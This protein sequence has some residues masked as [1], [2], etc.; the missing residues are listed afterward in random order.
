MLI[1]LILTFL[2]CCALAIIH[3]F[4]RYQKRELQIVIYLITV[5]ISLL[6]YLFYVDIS[7]FFAIISHVLYGA[8]SSLF[9]LFAVYGKR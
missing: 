4:L 8:F 6:C 2:S 9:I 5:F 3:E 7:E 1:S